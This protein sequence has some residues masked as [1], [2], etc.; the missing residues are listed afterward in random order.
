MTM[1][2]FWTTATS[3][4]STEKNGSV[5]LIRKIMRWNRNMTAIEQFLAE[6]NR[7]GEYDEYIFVYDK[8]GPKLY[9]VESNG[10]TKIVNQGGFFWRTA[11]VRSIEKGRYVFNL[12]PVMRWNED[13]ADVEQ[14]LPRM[15]NKGNYDEWLFVYGKDG[16]NLYFV[17]HNGLTE[18][19]SR[20]EFFWTTAYYLENQGEKSIIENAEIL[21]SALNME[22]LKNFFL[23]HGGNREFKKILIYNKNG[24]G[25]YSVRGNGEVELIQY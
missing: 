19:V 8:Y 17:E 25:H 2:F 11:T 14:F 7:K 1:G 20:E 22:D 16:L 24:L 23:E 5:F 15:N 10:S 13:M 12:N 6:R 3:I 21:R 18:K 4:S 9:F